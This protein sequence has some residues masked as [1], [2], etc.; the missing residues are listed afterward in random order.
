MRKTNQE[1]AQNTSDLGETVHPAGRRTAWKD[2]QGSEQDTRLR[3]DVVR[4]ENGIRKW[5]WNELQV[6]EGH[7]GYETLKELQRR[8]SQQIGLIPN[9]KPLHATLVY[10]G[11]PDDMLAKCRET[12]PNL[13]AQAF[14]AGFK[15]LMLNAMRA[16]RGMNV[17]IDRLAELH[18]GSKRLLVAVLEPNN[19][20]EAARTRVLSAWKDFLKTVGV[21]D[22]DSFIEGNED[23][24]GQFNVD[25]LSHITLGE[26]VQQ[27]KLPNDN[28]RGIEVKL[29]RAR[30]GNVEVARA[31]AEDGQRIYVK[32]E[33][34]KIEEM[35]ALA[36]EIIKRFKPVIEAHY[37]V[38]LKGGDVGS[39]TKGT[40]DP[41]VTPDIDPTFVGVPNVA[42]ERSDAGEEEVGY[43]DWGPIA[44][45]DLVGDYEGI[46]DLNSV[47]KVDLR[48]AN[49]IE[50]LIGELSSL[51][52]NARFNWVRSWSDF[53][54]L[55][56]NVGFEHP[57]H[58]HLDFDVSLYHAEN[59]FGLDHA[60]RFLTY[61]KKY[62]QEFG[63]EKLLGLINDIR[64]FKRLAKVAATDTEGKLD[65]MKKV[66]GFIAEALFCYEYPPRT[67]DQLMDL[68]REV[69]LSEV[70]VQTLPDRLQNI[71]DPLIESQ[72]NVYNVLLSLSRGGYQTVKQVAA[73][74]SKDS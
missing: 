64:K 25:Y 73:G 36:S 11:S 24:S 14:E 23:W 5:V 16:S 17:K 58:G 55:I 12:V 62:E 22:V 52:S 70:D 44:T 8:F 68:I 26:I 3:I 1:K 28:V 56:A 21:K 57:V 67:F 48:L 20:F 53:P 9:E 41:D 7:T 74:V 6:V 65:R 34:E 32:E 72:K 19:E 15:E 4:D 61:V 39:F 29:G 10:F 51:G 54:G 13:N 49:L 43:V 2:T 50:G 47:R 59:Y 33:L 27:V 60:E 18:Q 37:G 31:E 42:P 30:L 38:R 66:P 69:E 63:K 46:Q 71:T 45:Y 35:R 40:F